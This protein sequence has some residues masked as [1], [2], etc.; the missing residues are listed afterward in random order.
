MEIRY[1]NPFIDYGFKK[2]PHP[3]LRGQGHQ[4]PGRQGG[5]DQA[6]GRRAKGKNHVF[7]D[8]LTFIYLEMRKVG[9]VSLDMNRP[10][11]RWLTALY[12]LWGEETINISLTLTLSHSCRRNRR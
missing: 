3:L 8:K 9:R 1:I 7:Y 5:P 11:D 6:G 2:G 4:Q 12:R 10:L